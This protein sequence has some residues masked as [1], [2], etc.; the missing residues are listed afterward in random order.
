MSLS[1]AA[2]RVYD[3]AIA[4]VRERGEAVGILQLGLCA[5][6][7]RALDQNP[8]DLDEVERLAGLLEIEVPDLEVDR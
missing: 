5:D 4:L 2:Y 8:V 3:R 6:L 1:P 7:A